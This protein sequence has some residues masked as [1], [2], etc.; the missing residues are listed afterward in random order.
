MVFVSYYF[1]LIR[2]VA[3]AHLIVVK[4]RKLIFYINLL[5]KTSFSVPDKM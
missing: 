4:C 5:D 2:S 1:C 3:H